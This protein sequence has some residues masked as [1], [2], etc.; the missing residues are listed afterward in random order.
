MER[1]P[2][3]GGGNLLRS[4]R[5]DRSAVKIASPRARRLHLGDP[6]KQRVLS[7]SRGLQNYSQSYTATAVRIDDAFLP[8][9][10]LI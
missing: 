1:I 3:I 6:L 8:G 9:A 10:P 4:G 7:C 5:H 2:P